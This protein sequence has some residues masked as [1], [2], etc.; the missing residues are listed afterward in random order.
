VVLQPGT[1]RAPG[2]ARK[3]TRGHNVKSGDDFA[4]E[5][6]MSNVMPSQVIQTIDELFPRAK[7]GGGSGLLEPDSHG[8]Q[9]RG[10]LSLIKAIPADLLALSP[11]DYAEFAP[12]TSTFETHLERWVVRGSEVGFI[13]N[14]MDRDVVAVLRHVLV[15][16]PDEHPP[17]P[18][19]ELLFIKDG[20]LR[21]NIRRDIGAT[22]RALNNVEWKAATVLAGATIEALLHLDATR[23]F[24]ERTCYS[25]RHPKACC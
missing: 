13:P 17:A 1:G 24:A 12:A 21:E 7:S 23:T 11:S 2:S 10:I 19:A 8:T 5:G 4:I 14:I 20:G 22:N 25:R 3:V 16:C 9:L 6:M 15:K 18:T